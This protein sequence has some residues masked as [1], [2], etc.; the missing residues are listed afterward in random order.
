MEA[1]RVGDAVR[2]PAWRVP[3]GC[4]Q[5]PVGATDVRCEDCSHLRT[6]RHGSN[7]RVLFPMFTGQRTVR[8]G[9]TRI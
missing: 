3:P 8:Q 4:E 7:P 2:E 9:T 6:H 5:Y 1:I